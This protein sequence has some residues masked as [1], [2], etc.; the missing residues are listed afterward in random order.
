MLLQKELESGLVWCD[1]GIYRITK[2]LQ[3]LNLE[4][5]GNIFFGLGDFHF[6]KIGIACGEKYLEESGVENIF[7]E[8][9]I[10]GPEVA[11]CYGR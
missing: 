11:T 2:E 6:E 5:F 8:F 9:E 4:K 3:L 7:V 1:E 10:F